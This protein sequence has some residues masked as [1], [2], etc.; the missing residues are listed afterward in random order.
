LLIA[1]LADSE[2]IKQATTAAIGA[3]RT[4]EISIKR[5]GSMLALPKQVQYAKL[6][7][8]ILHSVA[9]STNIY[10]IWDKMIDMTTDEKTR[11]PVDANV[12]RLMNRVAFNRGFEN[13]TDSQAKLILSL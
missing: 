5:D 3:A 13:K 4:G 1:T 2:W 8:Y 7:N 6:F 12:K 10:D 9:G 11:K